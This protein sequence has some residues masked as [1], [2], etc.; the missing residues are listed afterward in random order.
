MIL[1]GARKVIGVFVLGVER[2]KQFLNRNASFILISAV[3]CYLLSIFVLSIEIAVA[4]D[5]D[6]NCDGVE[7]DKADFLTD[8]SLKKQRE[9]IV[10]LFKISEDDVVRKIDYDYNYYGD[11]CNFSPKWKDGCAYKGGHAGWD[12]RTLKELEIPDPL[13]V[14]QPFYSLTNGI[15]VLDGKNGENNTPHETRFNAIAIYDEDNDKT[16]F[17]L[18]ASDVHR[19]LKKGKKVKVGDPLGNQ[20]DTGSP[21]AIH[22]HLEVQEGETERASAGTKDNRTPTI[23]PISYLHESIKERPLKKIRNFIQEIF[24]KLK[25]DI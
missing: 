20:G 17:Y 1:T 5:E 24:A 12:V 23:D 19:L 21:G 8:E 11:S 7:F 9:I 13:P 15:V 4:C 6:A 3:V 14:D 10:K 16:T 22:V 25:V 2:M 18:H